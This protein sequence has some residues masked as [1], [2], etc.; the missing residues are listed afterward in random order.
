[1][2]QS[3]IAFFILL[4]L[5]ASAQAGTQFI[6]VEGLRIEIPARDQLV[7]HAVVSME[8]AKIMDPTGLGLCLRSTFHGIWDK[9]EGDSR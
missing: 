7:A 6:D 4:A 5:I 8:G 3:T 2:R 9:N 1:M